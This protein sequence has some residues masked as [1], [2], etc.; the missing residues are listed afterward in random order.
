LL[1]SSLESSSS[2]PTTINPPLL[3]PPVF[4]VEHPRLLLLDDTDVTTS[5]TGCTH[6]HTKGNNGAT[7]TSSFS[8]SLAATK[9]NFGVL[10]LGACQDR[11]TARYFKLG[12]G[13]FD[14]FP[15]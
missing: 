15:F 11:C 3:D 7:N 5:T 10:S 6:G 2:L 4:V 14:P 9:H 8:M 12:V 13:L 1:D